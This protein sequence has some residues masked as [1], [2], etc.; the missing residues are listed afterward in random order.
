MAPPNVLRSKN[1]F[2][3]AYRPDSD[4]EFDAHPELRALSE[5]W[6]RDNVL[7]N[8]GDLPRLYALSLN[9]KQVMADGIEGDFAE[10]GVYRGNSAAVLAFYARQH[11]R[12]I[13]LFDSFEGFVTKDLAGIDANKPQEFVDT[14]RTSSGRML[15]M[16]R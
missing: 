9:V 3:A 2:Y 1:R 15:A 4:V 7:N 6:V 14:Q 12:S 16:T 10:L 11:H 13:F 5:M 8:G